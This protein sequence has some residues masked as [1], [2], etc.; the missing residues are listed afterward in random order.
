M[1]EQAKLRA[2]GEKAVS[3]VRAIGHDSTLCLRE[4]SAKSTCNACVDVCPGHAV[5]IAKA[6]DMPG[7]SKVS[8]SKGFCVD[9]GLCCAVCPTSSM[10]VLE[11]TPRY[12]RHLLKRAQAA[13]GG[14]ERHVYLTC[15]ET[16]LAKESPSVVEVPCLGLI[17]TETWAS[18][19]LDFPNLAV[20][21]PG[22]LCPKCKAKVAE[23]MIVDAVVDAQGIVG[24]DLQLVEL[25]RELDFTDS[26][27]NVRGKGDE[28]D[29][30][31]D[32][33]S[34]FG[35][36]A[37]DLMHP[38]PDMDEVER[39]TS[40]MRKTRVRLR[41]EITAAEGEDTPGMQGAEELTG[42]V[43]VNRA[44]ILDAVMRFPDI[45][46][47]AVLRHVAV[48][49]SKLAEGQADELAA[50]CPLGALHKDEE[51]GALRVEKLVCVSCGLCKQIAPDAVSDAETPASELL[52]DRA[53]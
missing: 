21:L 23:G 35:D 44:T 5:R 19:M 6:Q 14:S 41:K 16:G 1:A 38:E 40:D 17:A 39:G 26:K 46:P 27:G 50:A 32:I 49:E 45:A 8:I 22:D 4:T 30:F 29:M 3:L 7:G 18:L 15:I 25:R 34:G 42:T 43:T 12:L 48:D 51:T 28:D 33:T 53:E 11:P 31:G 20:Y 9:C 10:L 24:R 13:A 47:R 52:A 2:A 37:K 36:I